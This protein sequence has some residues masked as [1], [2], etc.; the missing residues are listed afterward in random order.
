MASSV[1]L[2]GGACGDGA[3]VVAGEAEATGCPLGSGVAAQAVLPPR[4]TTE[5]KE[6]IKARI[7]RLVSPSHFG[8]IIIPPPTIRSVAL[9]SCFD[10]VA[11]RGR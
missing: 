10:Q 1:P 3:A 8:W 9:R 7:E 5:S 6:V 11:G 4:R 2:E